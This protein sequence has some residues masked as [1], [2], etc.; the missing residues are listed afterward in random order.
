MS[1]ELVGKAPVHP[2]EDLLEEYGFG[3]VCDPTLAVLE[4]HLLVCAACQ[5]KLEELDKYAAFMKTALARFE[6]GRK[7]RPAILRPWFALPGIP[8]ANAILAA[9]LMLVF[10][11]TIAWRSKPVPPT[12]TV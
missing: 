12:A 3:R 9:A 4:E 8:G 11:T 7:A 10:V 5:T 1:N 6:E 2:T